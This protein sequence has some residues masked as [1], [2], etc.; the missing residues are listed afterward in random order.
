MLPIELLR[1]RVSSKMNQIRP[2]FCDYENELSLPSKIIKMYEEMAEKKVSKAN[3]DENVSKIEAKYVDYK[4]VRGLCHLLEQRC[5]YASYASSNIAF[6]DNGNNNNTNNAIYLRRNIFE[7]SSRNGYPVTENER[8]YI[9]QK[10]ASKNNLTIDELELAMWNDLDKNKYLKNFDSLTSLQLV[11][12]YNISIIQ[13]VLLNCVKLEFSVYGGF[14]WKKILRKIKQ[15]GLMYFLY[16]EPN[17]KLASNN[18]IKNQ[19]MLLGSNNDKRIICTVDGPLSIV[20]LTDKYGMAMAKLIPLIIFTERWSIDATI[21]RKSMNGIKKTYNFQLSNRDKDL[22]IFDASHITSHTHVQSERDSEIGLSFNKYI[23]DSFDSNVEKKFMDKFLTFSTDWQLAREPDPLIL[24]DGK[25][26]IPDFVFEK[27]GVKVYLEIVGFWTKDYLKRKLE[28]IKDL[29]TNPVTAEGA[30]DLLI[31]A[32][33]DNYISENGEKIRI[34]SIFSKFIAKKN[35]IFYKKDE[36]P[37][38]PI[39]KYLKDID[40]K[41]IDD[42]SIN[43]YDT[44]AREIEKIIQNKQSKVIFLKEISDKHNI[45][46]ES[47]LK[48]IRN[49][50]SNNNNSKQATTN[51]IKNFLLVDNYMIS[52]DKI[53]ELLPELDKINKLHDAIWFLCENNIPEECITLLI[54]KIGFEIVWNGIDSNNALIQRQ[55]IKD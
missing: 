47:V 45:P 35:L 3:V 20:R 49:L 55:V 42:I 39:I 46:L 6:S 16:S 22:P 17:L 44:I 8:K 24:S 33:M 26:F 21:L 38:G 43:F 5:V 53:N 27:H 50:Q 23:M 34:D 4:L 51:G 15:L 31:A 32:N 37:F 13:T 11:A 52:N 2:V 41:I 19:D 7:E 29:T 36:I 1:V 54:P 12:W 10:V 48:T 30:A 28:K 14:N 25:A 18:Q 40:S 9:L